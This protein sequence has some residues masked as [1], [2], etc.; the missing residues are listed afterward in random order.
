MMETDSATNN[1][2]VQQPKQQHDPDR[3]PDGIMS[4][5]TSGF[6]QRLQSFMNQPMDPELEHRF[7]AALMEMSFYAPVQSGRRH[8]SAKQPRPA[9]T[10]SVAVTTYLADGY[11]YIPVFTD[12]AKMQRFMAGSPNMDPFRSFEFTSSELME[13]A[14]QYNLKGILINPGE[15]SFPLTLEY[16]DYIHQVA[17][18]VASQNQDEDFKYQLINPT[19]TKLEETLSQ[20]LRHIRKAKAA[21]LIKLKPNNDNSYQYT[22]LVDYH[23]KPNDFEVKVSRKLAMAAHRYLPYGA[24]IIVGRLEGRLGDEVKHNVDAFYKRTGWLSS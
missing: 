11:K 2:P 15:Q 21:W 23:G 24:D 14:E 22:V 13:E 8:A 9:F 3:H 10:V 6:S 20:S 16:W 7:A 18:V 4:F 1:H 17:P 5:R 19:P 12:L